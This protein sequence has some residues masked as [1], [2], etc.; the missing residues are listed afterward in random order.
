VVETNGTYEDVFSAWPALRPWR[1]F[2][3][4]TLR[5]QMS[6]ATK[7]IT[8]TDELGRWV[9]SQAR[10]R[11]GDIV[12]IPNA[13][14]VAMFRP[15][16][17]AVTEPYVVFVGALAP[18]QGVDVMIEARYRPEWPDGVRLVIAGDGPLRARCESLGGDERF[19]YLG[20]VP[21][22]TVPRLIARSIA[23]LSVQG[24][25]RD[26][27]RVGS[28]PLK[29]F[30]TLACGRP[31]IISDLP[32]PASL[33]RE[34]ECGVV[35]PPDDPTA[36]AEAVH[37]LWAN[38]AERDAMGTNARRLV[39]REHSWEARAA[40]TEAVLARAIADVKQAGWFR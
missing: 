11:A 14:D 6:A 17:D 24:R 10:L 36:L 13:A 39:L 28:S 19:S 38:V 7:V 16:D 37:Y 8:V 20:P 40:D 4:L 30:E 25:H 32:G 26:R 3:E 9:Q 27:E 12:V 18:W 33:V 34:H 23:G 1:R 22:S 31:L 21:H 5:L 15:E 35:V 29:A 2:V